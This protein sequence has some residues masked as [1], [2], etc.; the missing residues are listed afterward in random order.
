TAPL[1]PWLAALIG[2]GLVAFGAGFV[3]RYLGGWLALNVQHAVRADV[4]AS[5]SRLDG[6]RQD[7]LHTGQVVSRSISDIQ[8]IQALLQSLPML[9]GNLLLIVISLVCMLALS[10]T[11]SMVALA[12]A[13]AL[14]A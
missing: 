2:L 1:Q 11:L 9:A 5:L 13:P 8:Q 6:A 7:E 12:V 3:R 4:F 14:L 10:P